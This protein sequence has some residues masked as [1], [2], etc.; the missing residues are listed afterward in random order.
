MQ[1]RRV[2]RMLRTTGG[3]SR[4]VVQQ[5]ITSAPS[6][7]WLLGKG[8][9]AQHS[10]SG[11]QENEREQVLF[12]LQ[13]MHSTKTLLQPEENQRFAVISDKEEL[14]FLSETSCSFE[15]MELNSISEEFCIPFS[16]KKRRKRRENH[17]MM[18]RVLYCKKH[19]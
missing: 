10:S 9:I 15:I 3:S 11:T 8:F 13:I 18:D 14:F 12:L 2:K 7:C 4:A 1:A 19:L 5:T 17:K 6:K 16:L